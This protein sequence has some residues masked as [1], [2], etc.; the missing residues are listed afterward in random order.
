MGTCIP[1][2]VGEAFSF[3]LA[4]LPSAIWDFPAVH[5]TAVASL[6]LQVALLWDK[7]LKGPLLP[8]FFP[9]FLSLSFPPSP[10]SSTHSTNIHGGST[11][12]LAC[13]Y[14]H[15]QLCNWLR[16]MCFDKPFPSLCLSLPYFI[17]A[18]QDPVF[19]LA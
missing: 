4:I 17:N 7:I 15:N 1:C 12:Y 9:I 10:S 8:L 5:S 19:F 11:V 6:P 18:A 14:S 2:D 16:G 3:S 13:F